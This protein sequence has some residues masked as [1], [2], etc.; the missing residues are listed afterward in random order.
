MLVV[1]S[2]DEVVEVEVEVSLTSDP[3]Q[4]KSRLAW[5]RS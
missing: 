3:I 2:A 1:E 5:T 4:S